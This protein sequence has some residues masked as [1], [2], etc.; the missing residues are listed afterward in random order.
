MSRGSSRRSIISPRDAPAGSPAWR[1]PRN[2]APGF[3]HTNLPATE[4]DSATRLV[5]LIDVARQLWDSWEDRGFVVD[6]ASGTFADPTH[7]H[8]I[9]HAGR[10]FTVRGPLNVPRPV[11]GQPVIL[12]RDVPA[13]P[14]RSGAAASAE[15]VLAECATLAEAAASRRDWRALA[16][17][18]G[19]DPEGLRFIVRVMPIL[20]ETEQA[21]RKRAAE[22]DGLAGVDGTR[23]ACRGSWARPISLPTGSPNGTARAPATASTSFPPCCRSISTCWWRR[24]CRSCAAAVSGPPATS[25]DAARPSR[26]AARAQPLRRLRGEQHVARR[27]MHLGLFTYPGGHHI[28][29]WRHG[30]VDPHKILG[31]DYYRRSAV[32]AERG[33]F[34]LFFVG[35][36]LAAREKDGRVIAQGALNNIDSISITGALAGATEHLGL[37]ATLS[38]TYNEPYRHR[39]ALRHARSHQRRPRRLERHH[40]GERRRGAQLQPQVAHGKDAALRAGQGIRRDL[41]GPVGRLAGRCPESRPRRRRV[42][43]SGEGDDA[44]SHRASSSPCAARSNS[45]GRRRAGR[46]WCRPAARP[47]DWN[48]PRPSA[49]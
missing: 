36:M 4:E 28:A 26:P 21:A 39:R 2:W 1:G 18:Q 12:H 40:D 48:S 15:V 14:M 46:C 45:R 3:G 9:E 35:D 33:K 20:A 16:Q 27:P 34:D 31:Y 5:E 17:K 43:R 38:T 41:Q 11:Q 13:G 25:T 37:V 7:V 23:R 30:S 44:R 10:F 22:L 29:G 24:W 32:L 19:R 8:P 42:R 49:S 47:P 6:Q